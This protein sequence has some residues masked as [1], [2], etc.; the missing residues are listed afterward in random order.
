MNKSVADLNL[1]LKVYIN[2][3]SGYGCNNLGNA[4]RM[5][6]RLGIDPTQW[7]VYRTTPWLY[8]KIDI[9]KLIMSDILNNYECNGQNVAWEFLVPLQKQL[10]ELLE[11]QNKVGTKWV[12]RGL[13]EIYIP[14][15]WRELV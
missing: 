11:K 7:P 4:L 8:P 13:R 9:K 10:D 15:N 1:N 3:G 12:K 2:Y 5:A 14:D 6:K